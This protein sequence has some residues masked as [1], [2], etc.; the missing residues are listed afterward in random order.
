MS[1]LKAS[2]M[3]FDNRL[4]LG[5][6]VNDSKHEIV[7]KCD[8]CSKS[9]DSYVNCAYNECHRHY[10]SC[11]ECLDKETGYAF[12]NQECKENYF[13][14]TI[15]HRAQRGLHQLSWATSASFRRY[16]EFDCQVFLQKCGILWL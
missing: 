3:F 5:F 1:T 9:C 15:H 14:I 13:K 12:C 6:N 16:E 2:Y 10:I 4:T 8:H 11:S 7:G